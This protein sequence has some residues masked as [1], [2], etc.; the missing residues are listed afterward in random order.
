MA[1]LSVQVPFPVFYDRNGLPLDNG[2]IYIGTANT[3]ALTNQIQ[4]YYDKALTITA[5][6][7]LKTSNGYIYRNGTPAQ[8]YVN[9]DN[10][11]ISVRESNGVLVYNFPEATG[12]FA[13]ILSSELVAETKAV[14]DGALAS[15]P[16][17]S[18]VTVLVDES[19][20]GAQTLYKKVSGVYVFVRYLGDGSIFQVSIR[21]SLNK[22]ARN[23]LSTLSRISAD[24][25][26]ARGY[27]G[28]SWTNTAI[29]AYQSGTT[30]TASSAVF[31]KEHV[32]M[33]VTWA[34]GEEAVIREVNNVDALTPIA[35]CVLDRSQTVS[36]GAATVKSKHLVGIAYGDSLGWRIGSVL[37][38]LLFRTLGF[39]GY[40]FAPNNIET[41]IAGEVAEIEFAGGAADI[42]NISGAADY[43]WG[44][45]W[46]L[47]SGGAITWNL[48]NPFLLNGTPRSDGRHGLDPSEMYTDTAVVVW[49]RGAG[50]FR[51]ERKR[52][53]Q[54]VWETAATVADA[55]V[56]SS[57][58]SKVI[59]KHDLS[60]GWQ[61]RV[62]GTSGTINVVSFTLRNDTVAGYVHWPMSRGGE[63]MSDFD[64][65]TTTE[66]QELCQIQGSPDFRT[67]LFSDIISGAAANR[68][69]IDADRAL[70]Q[71]AAPRCDHVW[72]TTYE[73]PGGPYTEWNNALLACAIDNRDSLIPLDRVFG[74]FAENKLRGWLQDDLH[75]S[76]NGEAIIGHGFFEVVGFDRFPVV[77][78]G[79]DVSSR[80]GEFKNLNVRGV[81]LEARTR[82]LENGRVFSRGAKWCFGDNGWL[83]GSTGGA[84]G[85]GDF[86]ISIDFTVPTV[87]APHY[88]A[89]IGSN[90]ASLF[91][92]G[93]LNLRIEGNSLILAL[94]DASGNTVSYQLGLTKFA[95]GGQTGVLTVRAD[96]SQE[97]LDVFW[98]GCPSGAFYGNRTGSTVSPLGTWSGTG[99]TF[100]IPQ[101]FAPDTR[102]DIF[103]VMFWRSYLTD[104]E[105]LSVALDREPVTTIPD[106]WWDFNEG[107]GRVVLD[108][109]SNNRNALFQKQSG[110][111]YSVGTGPVWKYAKQSALAPAFD[112][113]LTA[114][115]L[116]IPGD[117]VVA[118][119]T[120]NR[121]MLLP[122]SAQLG[123]LIRVTVNT[124]SVIRIS[125]NASQQ[126]KS[127]ASA[128]TVGTGG[129]L[130]IPN[131]SSVSLRCVVGGAS[132]I[133]VIEGASGAALTFT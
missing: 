90:Y 26:A 13:L 38:K 123:D 34:S 88:L 69:A 64:Q 66:L 52:L 89:V 17:N 92:N 79:R 105:I 29:T 120:A 72:M 112:A 104:S 100:A 14:A 65:I 125:Q 82:Q 11:S 131:A 96:A 94:R 8:V 63:L 62:V 68:A 91:E 93:N 71:A 77:R 6:Q 78:E 12:I 3:D 40:V 51:V 4:V 108:K 122:A 7:P 115:V 33:R 22:N 73:G 114:N 124:A 15:L 37:Q 54:G 109:T 75:P 21:D 47:P 10:F 42:S 113:S 24:F 5:T 50:A 74:T 132:T 83:V 121:D 129:F 95:F 56:G 46:T 1:T 103:G 45:R 118:S 81:D 99:T 133:W 80:N 61:Y 53:W 107:I 60:Y 16:E 31:Y 102:M 87:N 41:N 27:N 111:V 117:D 67:V 30:L 85:T 59:V 55:S 39:G 86:T 106:F 84:I 116:L 25:M 76:Q 128:T 2:D 43:P 101:G 119:F 23:S 9:A 130:T 126:I 58:F 28:Q 18:F 36:N 70:W 127:G 98:N 32:G 57:N 110:V 35:T 48:N 20:N 49:R 19:K 44:Q 97:R